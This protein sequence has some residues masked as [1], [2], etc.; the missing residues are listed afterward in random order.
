[1]NYCQME[2]KE[3]KAIVEGLLFASGDEGVTVN[4]VAKV[5]NMN[6]EDIEEL[7][8][9]LAKSYQTNNRGMM[10]MKADDIYHLT[11][12]PEHSEYFKKLIETPHSQRLSQAALETLAIIA[13]EQPI[14][15]VEISHIRG[16]NSDRPVQTLLARMLIEEVGRKDAIGRPILFGT[17]KDFL[18]YFGLASIEELPPLPADI[19]EEEVEEE[20]TLLFQKYH[21]QKENTSSTDN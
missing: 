6:Q 20:A 21:E 9:E 19:N 8:E 3:K 12:R 2:W 13:Y 14:T 16:V 10:M 11:T 7:L 1:M 15:R 4:Q 5:L 17:S 18:T